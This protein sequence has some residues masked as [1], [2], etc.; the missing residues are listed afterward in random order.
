VQRFGRCNRAGEVDDAEIAWINVQPKD[1][2]DE[3]ALP[4][5]ATELTAAR[6][7][8]EKITDVGPKSLAG[9][10]VA[11]PAIVR[12]V[13]RRRDLV[14]LFDTTPDL[15]GQDLDISRYIRDGEDSDVQ[16]YWRMIV[17]ERPPDDEPK[18]KRSELCRVSIGE[19]KK[20]LKK[21][22][23]RA[24]GWNPLTE[25]WEKAAI[26]R[27]GAIY[28]VNADS[29]GYSDDEGWTAD[30]KSEVTPHRSVDEGNDAFDR[31]RLSFIR[32]WQELDLHTTEVV[33]MTDGL[34]AS[35]K[36]DAAI[37]AILRTAAQW[38]DVGKAHE[39]F[40][41]M[42]CGAETDRRGRIWAKSELSNGKCKRPGFRHELASALAW[43]LHGPAEAFERDLIAFVVA[44]HHGRVRLSIRALPDEKGPAENGDQPFARGVWHGDTL[45]PVSLAGVPSTGLRL[46]LSL[47]RMG[48]G[49]HGPSWL[50]RMI[51]L[52][53]RVGPFRLAYLETLLRAAD[54][55]ASADA[56]AATLQP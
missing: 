56:A 13:L 1:D 38:H 11:E 30:P 15:C 45:L 10:V 35:L 50:A 48:D 17:G 51:S 31:D 9:I 53:D 12:P 33:E 28:L 6:T 29:G 46:D 49:E 26:P 55:R 40:Q 22:K 21:D 44:A 34:A 41:A 4:Y 23:V 20:F 25:A 27:S 16:F 52:R 7:E 43:L 18:P 37:S 47:M 39:E 8:L 54:M 24:W 3:L 2:K 19:A 32:H 42:L 14:D 36:L 5:S